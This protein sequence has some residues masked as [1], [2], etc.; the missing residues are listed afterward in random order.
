MLPVDLESS[1][2][3]INVRRRGGQTSW[4]WCFWSIIWDLIREEEYLCW[5]SL[6][7]VTRGHKA[8]RVRPQSWYLELGHY[9]HWTRQR[10]ATICWSP[11]YE[12]QASLCSWLAQICRANWLLLFY[13]V[14]LI[15]NAGSLP[16]SEEPAACVGR[17]FFQALPGVRIVVLAT[18]SS[19]CK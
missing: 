3:H 1:R 19:W 7:D 11:S 15:S 5:N 4:L 10:R 18:R 16:Y 9:G 13:V 8:K 6:L 12:G 14:N 17:Q 2:Q